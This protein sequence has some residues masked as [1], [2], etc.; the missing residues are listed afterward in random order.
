MQTYRVKQ[1]GYFM[2]RYYEE[3]AELLLHRRQAKYALMSGQLE[4]LN[5]APPKAQQ[6]P[7]EK[8]GPTTPP[9]FQLPR[10][11]GAAPVRRDKQGEYS[12]GRSVGGRTGGTA[13]T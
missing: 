10:G 11:G 12:R 1:A 6:K 13:K 9:T 5:P 7:K 8:S 2:G 4:E 3:G